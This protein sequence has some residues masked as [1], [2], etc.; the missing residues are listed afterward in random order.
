MN[1]SKKAAYLIRFITY[2][3]YHMAILMNLSVKKVGTKGDIYSLRYL[4]AIRRKIDRTKSTMNVI[5]LV[6][7]PIAREISNIF[8]NMRFYTE[9]MND[10]GGVNTEKTV[11]HLNSYFANYD[12][13][14]DYVCTWFDK[15]ILD[16]FKIDVY[17]IPFDHSRA[18]SIVANDQAKLLLLRME[19]LPVVFTEAIK[20][21]IGLTVPLIR[22]NEA[23]S[24]EYYEAYKVVSRRIILPQAVCERVYASRFAQHFYSNKLR[25]DFVKKWT[26]N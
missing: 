21:F 23:S 25:S 17:A 15:E 20:D 3:F 4:R 5:S 16:T 18:Y 2:I 10:T 1:H 7:D 22:S 24:K 8:H 9:L 19:D 26:S 14:S 12:E 11:D 13:E 6:R